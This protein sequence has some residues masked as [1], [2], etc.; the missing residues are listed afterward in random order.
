LL[1]ISGLKIGDEAIEVVSEGKNLKIL[2]ERRFGLADEL[3]GHLIVEIDEAI[4]LVDD[5]GEVVGVEED[6]FD[7]LE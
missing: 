2:N 6:R 5:V 3:H 4:F 7:S 1:R